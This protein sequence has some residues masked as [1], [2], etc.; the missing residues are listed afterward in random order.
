M[1]NLGR[2]LLGGFSAPLWP[3]LGSLS[4]LDCTGRAM[5]AL[6]P[7]LHF[8]AFFVAHFLC[9]ISPFPIIWPK[10]YMA[11]RFQENKDGKLPGFLAAGSGTGRASPL[12]HLFERENR[13]LFLMEE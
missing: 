12:Y 10:L 5:K 1:E 2:A 11:A 4:W 6:L 8:S 9:G 7:R 13:S 3:V